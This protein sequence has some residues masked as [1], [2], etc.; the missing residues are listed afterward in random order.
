MIKSE[1]EAFIKKAVDRAITKGKP[2][3]M[4]FASAESYQN[5]CQLYREDKEEEA[6]HIPD[7]CLKYW[8]QNLI[9]EFKRI[10]KE[11]N[12][13]HALDWGSKAAKKD[14]EKR[15]KKLENEQD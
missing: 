3:L 15:K 4:T 7:A 14:I 9:P 6:E 1:R 8:A 10:A 2:I 11:V 12:Y 13:S 5:F